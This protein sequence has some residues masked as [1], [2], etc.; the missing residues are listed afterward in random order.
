MSLDW[1]LLNLLGYCCQIPMAAV[2]EY[3]T[4]YANRPLDRELLTLHQH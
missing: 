3:I 4:S 1:Q 2:F